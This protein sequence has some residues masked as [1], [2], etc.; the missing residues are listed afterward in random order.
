LIGSAFAAAAPEPAESED[1]LLETLT[2]EVEIPP[3][4]GGPSSIAPA[5]PAAEVP[6]ADPP[7]V[8]LDRIQQY[9]RSKKRCFKKQKLH[10]QQVFAALAAAPGD[11]TWRLCTTAASKGVL[12]DW[13]KAKQCLAEAGGK[14]L[15]ASVRDASVPNLTQD[16]LRIRA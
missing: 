5:T 3:V 8:M 10:L 16:R 7:K 9:C 6:M 1:Q 2:A 13:V 11:P 12:T 14:A 4:V 15:V